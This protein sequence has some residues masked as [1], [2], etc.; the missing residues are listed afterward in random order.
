MHT[1]DMLKCPLGLG[2]VGETE[3]HLKIHIS[4]HNSQTYVDNFLGQFF[5]IKSNHSWVD[6]INSLLSI[7]A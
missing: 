1:V 3:R 4:K 5:G 2:Y 6:D 7:E